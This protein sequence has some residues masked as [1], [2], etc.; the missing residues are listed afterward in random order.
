M[1]AGEAGAGAPRQARDVMAFGQEVGR[2]LSDGRVAGR[3]EPFAKVFASSRLV[4]R[5]VGL[6]A[7]G[8]LEDI[9]LDASL[10]AEGRLVAE[11]SARAIAGN[12]GV[13]KETVTR[14]LARLRAHGFVLHEEV[15]DHGS[16]RY[17][18]ARYVLDPAACLERFTHT[19]PPGGG[20]PCT[21]NPD[22]VKPVSGK[23]VHGSAG[24]GE[25]G[26][27]LL[28][29]HVVVGEQQQQPAPSSSTDELWRLGVDAETAAA[30]VAA[31]GGQRVAAV[32]AAA[33]RRRPRNPAGW[34]I[35]ALKGG[36][37]LRPPDPPEPTGPGDAV[38]PEP[39][40]QPNPAQDEA[41][42]ARGRR[43]QA[44]D[45][46]VS[47]ALDDDTLARAVE[48]ACPPTAGMRRVA[49]AVQ[50]A[51][52]R[53]SAAAY[54]RAEN[55]D[56]AAALS[57]ALAEGWRDPDGPAPG[58]L[59]APPPVVAAMPA[60]LRARLECL[61]TGLDPPSCGRHPPAP[62]SPTSPDHPAPPGG[63]P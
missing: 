22:T 28:E 36:W 61:V 5:A 10:D 48:L 49:P 57:G 63:T 33:H 58:E 20:A 38:W 17:E 56:L 25:S 42:A 39:A 1:T 53:W 60:P 13:N 19:P 31:H 44:W 9:A 8:V 47:A 32:V 41:E 12:L 35:A 2:V 62:D 21:E 11:T 37:E 43:W 15:R 6:T 18:T 50:A 54:R 51:V 23:P 27:R 34:A 3:A 30:L 29:E 4:K 7:W 46:A 24:H 40:I 14:H 26:H 52:I 16:G 59:P 45:S 55:A